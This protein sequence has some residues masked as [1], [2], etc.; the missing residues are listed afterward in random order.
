MSAFPW[1]MDTLSLI[2]AACRERVMHASTRKPSGPPLPAP[3][4][5]CPAR[6]AARSAA[7]FLTSF[8]IPCRGPIRAS[9]AAP[10]A[11]RATPFGARLTSFAPMEISRRRR[12]L[13]SAVALSPSVSAARPMFCFSATTVKYRMSPKLHVSNQHSADAE[14]VDHCGCDRMVSSCAQPS[15]RPAT[16][17]AMRAL[18]RGMFAAALAAGLVAATPG[19]RADG[20]EF[21][22]QADPPGG[23]VLGWRRRRHFRAH[24]DPEAERELGTA[25]GDREPVGR[26]RQARRGA[27][28]QGPPDGYTLLWTSSAFTISRGAVC[29]PSVRSAQGLCGRHPA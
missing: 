25:G 26:R 19:H 15:T 2:R 11:V 13:L 16:G 23:A 20:E 1:R 14:S 10:T 5:T 7:S 17:G 6:P 22:Q 24:R 3:T 12:L 4:F 27:R 18:H 29:G 21:P 28:R 9:S 8:I